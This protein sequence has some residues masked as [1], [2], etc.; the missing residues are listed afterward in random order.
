MT[1]EI[2]ETPKYYSRSGFIFR[3]LGLIGINITVL[4]GS[5][6]W[7]VSQRI[8]VKEYINAAMHGYGPALA[9]LGVVALT[10]LVTNV[11]YLFMGY[12]RMQDVS[13]GHMSKL[14]YFGMILPM[15]LSPIVPAVAGIYSLLFLGFLCCMP[16]A[17][18]NGAKP[19]WAPKEPGEVKLTIKNPFVKET[20]TNNVDEIAKLFELKEKGAIT[21]EEFQEMKKKRVA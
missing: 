15:F 3:T 2:K 17:F 19:L 6:G 21:E 1:E 5:I 10:Y 18:S 16:G 9:L 11:V 7:L 13:G 14:Q 8:P 12:W 4:G 20:V